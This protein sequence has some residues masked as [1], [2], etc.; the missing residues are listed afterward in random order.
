M[1]AEAGKHTEL[2][3]RKGLLL[4]L[5]G[6][7]AELAR[8][9]EANVTGASPADALQPALQRTLAQY[10]EAAVRGEDSLGKRA[11]HNAPFPVGV[12]VGEGGR[13][14][15]ARIVP[16]LH[17]CTGGLALSSSGEV[18]RTDGSPIRGLHAAGEVTG[19]VHGNN[20]LGGNSLLECT[21]Y[22]SIVGEKLPIAA[23]QP[24]PAAAAADRLAAAASPSIT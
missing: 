7:T 14:Y 17:Y 19:G 8:W 2:Y 4:P 11:F 21:V 22:G 13:L 12:D 20:R 18:L 23:Q 3:V 1:A 16:S 15:A 9:M 6:G 10:N 5:D 24:S